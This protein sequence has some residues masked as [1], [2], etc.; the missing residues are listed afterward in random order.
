MTA[1]LSQLREQ[2]DEVD[3]VLL[4]LLAKRMGLVA[5]VGEVKS[6][7]GLPIYVPEREI[8]MLSS[9]RQEAEDMGIPPDLIEDILRRIM[10]ES[11][12]SE[13]NQ[14]FKKLCPHLGPVVI[15]G[16]SGKMGKLF[17]R[18]LTLSGYDVRILETDDWDNAEYIVADAGMVIVSVPI[19]LTEEVIRRLPPLPEQCI[20]VDLASIKHG[21]L[22]AMIDVHQ[23]PVLGL[24]PMFGPDV[25]S[26]AKQV[27]VYCDGR[28][29]E[30]YQWFLE[31]IAVWGAHL[32][33]ISAEQ[34]DKSMS[35]I[36]AL[37]HF[38]TFS[39]GRHLAKENVDLQQLLAL[40][41][42]IYRLELAMVGRLFAQ[43]PQLYADII[44]SSPE[45]IKQIRRYHQSFGQALEILENRDKLAFIENFNQ[46]SEWFGD[47][48][49][50]FMK[51]SR[52]L[53]QQASDN[54]I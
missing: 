47:E 2:I 44:M 26:F 35:F 45:N 54:R 32:H 15:V 7:L 51:E 49:N 6:Q 30:A 17:G 18:L 4:A 28:R 41:S 5:Q 38:T 19:H 10:R 8:E 46:V 50:R 29:P 3:K 34:H 23:G 31:Q 1:E 53:L 21:P 43:D 27:V 33:Q 42:P 36:Q 12:V 11:Y 14:G 20:L 9:R 24:H 16:G 40:S 25:G 48:A 37:R 39:Y 13:N 22:H 52:V